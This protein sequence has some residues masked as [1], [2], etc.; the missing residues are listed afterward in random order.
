M[1]IFKKSS[2]LQVYSKL[3]DDGITNVVLADTSSIGD[4]WEKEDLV[5]AFILPTLD[6]QMHYSILHLWI[7]VALKVKY[8]IHTLTEDTYLN[9]CRNK[10]IDRANE[11]SARQFNRLPDYFMF[12]DQDMVLHP[13]LFDVLKSK[14]DKHNIDIVSAHYIRK[15]GNLPV[16]TAV[17]YFTEWNQKWKFKRGDL[18]EVVTTGAGA[19]LVKGEVLRKIDPPWFKTKSDAK[20]FFGEDAYFCQLCRDNGYKVWVATDVP[21][22]HQGSIV[23]PE[24]FEIRGRKARTLDPWNK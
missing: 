18:L 8:V 9:F 12:I 23:F 24:D 11:A 5:V 7:A 21:C 20:T 14:M 6:G 3:D 16:W 19:L 1:G 17:K 4:K 10:L 2:K 13:D 22:G 15:R